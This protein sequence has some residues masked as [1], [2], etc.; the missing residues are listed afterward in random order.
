MP[1]TTITGTFIPSAGRPDGDS[2]R[3]RPDNPDPIF[4]LRRR[5]RGPKIN[6]QNQ[7]IQLRFEGIDTMESSAAEPFS[8]DATAS[9]LDLCGVPDGSDG[10]G[11]ILSNQLGPNGRPISFVF[12][13]EPPDGQA[14]GSDVFLDAEQMESSVNFQQIRRG[15]A[16]PLFYDTLFADLRM[17]LT[18]AV[19]TAR[20]AGLGIWASDGTNTGVRFAGRSSL[21]TMPPVFPKLWRR[22]DKYSRDQD[23]QEPDRLDEFLDFL[24]DGRDERV[25][26]VSRALSTGFDNVLEVQGDKI[27]MTV[28]PEDL[29]VVSV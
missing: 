10:R 18:D 16:Y 28:Q 5:G 22:L 9:N 21:G 14:D 29:V 4:R 2:I 12:Q 17:A 13:G 26:V 6:R 3:F 11:Y 19:L 7:T 1:F 20:Q 23:I 25:F 8:S 15:H 24:V 27:K